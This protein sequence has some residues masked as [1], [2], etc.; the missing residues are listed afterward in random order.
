[1]TGRRIAF[2]AVGALVAVVALVLVWPTGGTGPEPIAYGGDTCARCRMIISRPGF[3][4]E[5][6]DRQGELTKYDDVGCL[7]EA[8]LSERGEMPEAW[9]EDYTGGSLVP[10]LHATLVR[11]DP[12][13]TPMGHGIVAFADAGAASAF[14]VQRGGR[15]VALEELVHEP[16]RLARSTSRGEGRAQR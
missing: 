6:R 9:V 14:A 7:L 15:I 4:G 8:M 12:A 2:A 16:D 1:V 11:I 5:L 3:A 13:G 10:L